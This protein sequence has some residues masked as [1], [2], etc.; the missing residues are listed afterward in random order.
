VRE[1][2][3]R[4][5]VLL[6]LALVAVALVAVALLSVLVVEGVVS[7]GGEAVVDCESSFFI[8]TEE[9]D[10]LTVRRIDG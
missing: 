9:R 3:R 7:D 10:L 5:D 4:L 8:P 1:G 6:L 2:W